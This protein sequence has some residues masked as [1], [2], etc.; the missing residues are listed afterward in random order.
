MSWLEN[1]SRVRVLSLI[2]VSCTS[3]A[4]A[5]PGDWPQFRGPNRD[6]ISTETGLLKTW[7]Q[8]GPPLAWKATGLG[9][10]YAGVAVSGDQIYTAGDKGDSTLVSALN[11]AD[12]KPVW[13]AKLGRADAPGNP[14]FEGPRS[15]P[16][17]DGDLVFV[18]GQWGD[19]VCY[20]TGS[21]KEVWHK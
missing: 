7:P 9:G 16:T 17:V 19:L 4:L 12:G 2:L 5:G 13:S 14:K 18:L 15:T 3:A 11:R 6:D 1:F 21:G 8:D 20:E 10:G